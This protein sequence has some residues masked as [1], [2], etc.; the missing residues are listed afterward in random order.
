MHIPI[1]TQRNE[2]SE[3]AY[4]RVYFFMCGNGGGKCPYVHGAV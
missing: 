3:E 1:Q 4:D 2:V